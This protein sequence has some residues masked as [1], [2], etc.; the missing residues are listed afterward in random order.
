MVDDLKRDSA[1]WKE[2]KR[3]KRT[4]SR[5]T[6]PTM[7]RNLQY[8]FKG[9]TRSQILP[10]DAWRPAQVGDPRFHRKLKK[11]LLRKDDQNLYCHKAQGQLSQVSHKWQATEIV[12]HK[13]HLCTRGHLLRLHPSL[14]QIQQLSGIQRNT[15]HSSLHFPTHQIR[16]LDK[17]VRTRP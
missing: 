13:I 1:A 6:L 16:Q 14:Q 8:I 11:F 12:C 9:P 15:R 2:E 4:R 3:R 7:I 5:Y 10:I 17:I